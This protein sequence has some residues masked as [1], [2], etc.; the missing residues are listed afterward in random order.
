[1]TRF[2]ATLTV[3]VAF[4]YLIFGVVALIAPAMFLLL[5]PRKALTQ[6]L[7][8]SQAAFF[9]I[10]YKLATAGPC[11]FIAYGCIRHRMWGRYLLIAY[12][13]SLLAYLSFAFV[14]QWVTEPKSITSSTAG[15]TLIPFLILAA[16]IALV[17]QKDVKA[18]MSD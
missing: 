11:F 16:L 13:A 7:F 12:N 18:L 1:M 14:T 10:G 6:E 4:S 2:P 17:C 9:Y 3:I 8:F 15:A 5:A